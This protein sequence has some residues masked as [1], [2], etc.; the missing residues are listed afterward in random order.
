MKTLKLTSDRKVIPEVEIME[1]RDADS[2]ED[3][4]LTRNNSIKNLKYRE[5]SKLSEGKTFGELALIIH[6]PR[7]ATIKC[8]TNAYFAV[9]GK[10]DF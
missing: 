1:Y 2:I 5:V 9:L 10:Y 8:E 6:K 7:M 4:R 3:E